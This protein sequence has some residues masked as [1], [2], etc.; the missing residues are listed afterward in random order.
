MDENSHGASNPAPASGGA[1]RYL[2]KDNS[3]TILSVEWE[4]D[5]KH[6]LAESKEGTKDRFLRVDPT[7]G[8][9]ERLKVETALPGPDFS[10]SADERTIAYAYGAGDAPPEVWAFA[11]GGS[12]RKLASV[13]SQAGSWRLGAVKEIGWKNKK[14]SRTIYGVLVTPPDFSAGQLYPTIVEIHGGPEWAWWSGWLGSWHLTGQS[15]PRD[16]RMPNEVSRLS[17]V[18]R[19]DRSSGR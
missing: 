19:L 7:T 13:N 15:L 10:V 12:P 16:P 4:A 1:I 9:W 8:N 14:D 3:G 11:A 2:L 5:S 6:F 18:K 17:R